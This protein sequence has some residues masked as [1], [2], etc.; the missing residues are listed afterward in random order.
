MKERVKNV[1]NYKKPAFWIILVA[2]IAGVVLSVCFLTNPKQKEDKLNG[3]RVDL[4]L[5]FDQDNENGYLAGARSV[6]VNG[7]TDTV[8]KNLTEI[9]PGDTLVFLADCYDSDMNFHD[10]YQFGNPVTIGDEAVISNRYLPDASSA[11]ITYRFTDLYNQP[12]WVRIE[13]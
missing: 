8:A 7:E 12:H 4:I 3:V 6:Y 13:R 10:S 2:V 9:N 11:V 1:L 5:V